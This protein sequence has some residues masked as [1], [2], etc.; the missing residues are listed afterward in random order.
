MGTETC[1][2]CGYETPTLEHRVQ[3][4]VEFHEAHV[5]GAAEFGLL[6]LR[7]NEQAIAAAHFIDIDPSDLRIK[8]LLSLACLLILKE[9]KK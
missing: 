2:R 3:L 5:Q 4:Q 7:A 1:S 6:W 9:A 8:T